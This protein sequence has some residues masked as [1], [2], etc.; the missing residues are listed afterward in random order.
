MEWS[1]SL[2]TLQK[3]VSYL[4]FVPVVFSAVGINEVD[5]SITFSAVVADPD[6]NAN[7]RVVGFESVDLDFLFDNSVFLSGEGNLDL[8][9]LLGIF[10]SPG[11]YEVIAR[12]TDLAGTTGTKAFNVDVSAPLVPSLSP[13]GMALL[14]SLMGLAGWR[15]LHA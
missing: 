15:R 6:L 7:A 4:N 11:T 8:A 10:G 5:G 14:G 9:T 2:A 1:A 13:F 3:S 12:A